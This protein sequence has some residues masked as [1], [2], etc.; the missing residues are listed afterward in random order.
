MRYGDSVNFTVPAG[1]SVLAITTTGAFGKVPIYVGVTPGSVHRFTVTRK[2]YYVSHG[3][4]PYNYYLKCATHG[5]KVYRTH[6]RTS[7]RFYISWSSEIN[8]QT[9]SVKDY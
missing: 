1:V 7:S 4:Y 9:P 6:G 3:G 8:K 2:H 5:G